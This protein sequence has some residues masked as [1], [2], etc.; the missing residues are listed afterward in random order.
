MEN[1]LAT[2]KIFVEIYKGYLDTALTG[3]I[4]FYTLTGAVVANYL[5]KRKEQSYLHFSLVVPFIFGVAVTVIS[6]IGIWQA[7]SLRDKVYTVAQSL[8]IRGAPPVD[9]LT[10]F[11]IITSVLS[12][13]ICVGLGCLFFWWPPSILDREQ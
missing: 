5:S 13:T 2:Y 6:I 3:N 9:I 12:F 1:D 11:L 10:L 8:K 7:W 4:W